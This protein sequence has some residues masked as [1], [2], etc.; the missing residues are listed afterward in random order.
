MVKANNIVPPGIICTGHCHFKV[1]FNHIVAD[2]LG[3]IV[4]FSDAFLS[5]ILNYFIRINDS[6]YRDD[7]VYKVNILYIQRIALDMQRYFL[8][9]DAIIESLISETQ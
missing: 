3:A 2:L 6:S 7:A 9:Q 8:W 4:A 1:K 5:Q